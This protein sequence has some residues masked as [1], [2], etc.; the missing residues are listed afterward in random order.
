MSDL[1]VIEQVIFYTEYLRRNLGDTFHS[2]FLSETWIH[3]T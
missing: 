3:T 2:N 1:N